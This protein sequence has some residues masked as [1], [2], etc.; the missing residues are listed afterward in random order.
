MYWMLA[1]SVSSPLGFFGQRPS[2]VSEVHV[3]AVRIEGRA[4]LSDD[5][6]A[7]VHR[8]STSNWD[9]VRLR[10]TAIA[11]ESCVRDTAMCR[12]LLAMRSVP[13]V[14]LMVVAGA[15]RVVYGPGCHGGE[16]RF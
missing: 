10:C 16:Q 15:G 9:R 4:F 7:L 5:A 8:Y 13:R 1:P 11:D 14:A 2:A 6:R 12:T 3:L